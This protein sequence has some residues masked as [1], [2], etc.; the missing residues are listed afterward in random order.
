MFCATACY[1]VHD[2]RSI[3]RHLTGA[4]PIVLLSALK[5]VFGR[6]SARANR[7]FLFC[8]AYFNDSARYRLWID[9]YRDR[10]HKLE[11]SHLILIDDGSADIPGWADL[12][13]VDAA[14]PLPRKLPPG[15]YLFTFKTHLGRQSISDYPG[16]WRSFLYS[17]KIADRYGFDRIIHI[18]S[19]CFAL[20]ENMFRYIRDTQSGWAAPWCRA[21]GF[22][23]TC[24]QIICSDA[25]AE[26]GKLY[27][28]GSD[29][30]LQP[31]RYAELTL[32]F[33]RSEEH[34][35]ELQSH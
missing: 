31:A 33:T 3:C 27:K 20:S 12:T 19:D 26:L 10:M 9:Y 32:P 21:F 11:V 34:T 5:S 6:K 23:E 4:C 22:A 30:Y 29:F 18:E 35:S 13:I 8:T 1:T 24:F 16:W 17:W 14:D 25:L 2:R 15:I 7:S 28:Q